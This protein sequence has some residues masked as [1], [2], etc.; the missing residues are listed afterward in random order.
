MANL[1]RV[2][3]LLLATIMLVPLLSGIGRSEK[4]TSAF[5]RPKIVIGDDINY[6]PYSYLDPNG[7]PAGF[8]VELAKA[9]GNAMGY[10][11]IIKLDEWSKTREAL[12]R[13]Q[14]SGGFYFET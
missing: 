13:A 14:K 1:K 4:Q 9:V 2:G 12:G 3:L 7:M 10:D 6:P 8:N 11:V 5:E